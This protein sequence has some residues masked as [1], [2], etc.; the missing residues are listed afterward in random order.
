[1][2]R[3]SHKSI[4]LFGKS[5]ELVNK[6]SEVKPA[7]DSKHNPNPRSLRGMLR[8]EYA[9]FLSND[10]LDEKVSVKSTLA[11]ASVFRSIE[12]LAG[13][14]ENTD[15]FLK[16]KGADGSPQDADQH[17]CWGLSHFLANNSIPAGVW[18]GT[19]M[20][21]AL[22][23]TCGLS[24]IIRDENQPYY[25]DPIRGEIGRPIGLIPL[26]PD[27][28]AWGEVAGELWFFKLDPKGIKA[29]EP[30][31]NGDIWQIK[32]VS[33]DGVDGIDRVKALKSEFALILNKNRHAKR[34]Y[35]SGAGV[36]GFFLIPPGK[37]PEYYT[38][39]FNQI[40]GQTE[41]LQRMGFKAA[42][43]FDGIEWKPVTQD[44]ERAQ[45]TEAQKITPR[46]I[47]TIYGVPPHWLGDDSRTSL[48][49]LEEENRHALQN[50]VDFWFKRIETQSN[51]KL[52]RPAEWLSRTFFHKFDRSDFLVGDEKTRN[53]VR[54]KNFHGG[55]LGWR[56]ARTEMDKPTE[57]DDTFM[58]PAN[59]VGANPTDPSKPVNDDDGGVN[60][61]NL[62]PCKI[63]DGV[64]VPIT[65]RNCKTI[66]QIFETECSRLVNY[67]S[68][69]AV[70]AAAK[71][72]T[73]DGYL[74]RLNSKRSEFESKLDPIIAL[75][76][77]SG[78][79]CDDSFN[80]WDKAVAIVEDEYGKPPIQPF[81]DRMK[82]RISEIKALVELASDALVGG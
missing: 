11:I 43:L 67:V 45:L 78:C 66:R 39:F 47:A 20:F 5:Y 27:Y 41:K 22:T 57:T 46:T 21:H 82:G 63:I 79:P 54:L 81:V 25:E 52:L 77:N 58:V 33:R 69:S 40:E 18:R 71:P 42:P 26:D 48:K 68:K 51:W 50:T 3:Q 61:N 28:I 12:I 6:V 10:H 2:N 75:S 36:S 62:V 60:P 30:V 74:K 53:A 14:A 49:S 19:M 65:G 24:E 35:G 16:T 80:L 8:A 44:A 1:M 76:L 29:P 73:F 31:H 9:D 23:N 37:G 55:L 70:T 34:F 4:N 15:Y 7:T 72:D 38:N 56:E 32:G 17:E 59:I 64:P 13:F